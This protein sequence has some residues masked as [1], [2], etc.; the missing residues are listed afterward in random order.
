MKI[1]SLIIVRKDLRTIW[2]LNKMK[3]TIKIEFSES[4]KNVN[5][6]VKIEYELNEEESEK[7]LN[8]DILKESI[9]LFDKA[10]AYAINKTLRKI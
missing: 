9:E 10:N 6:D 2:R 8:S 3:K 7:Y 4:S 5:A 1:C